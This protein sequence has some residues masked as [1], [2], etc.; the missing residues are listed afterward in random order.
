M[1]KRIAKPERPKRVVIDDW[2]DGEAML[3]GL[4]GVDP[5]YDQPDDA[6]PPELKAQWR[7]SRFEGE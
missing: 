6:V 7:S 5:D 2:A 3:E 1:M 4:G